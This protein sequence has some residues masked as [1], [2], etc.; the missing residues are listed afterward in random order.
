MPQHQPSL[1]LLVLSLMF[2][3]ACDG[4][5][6]RT[7]SSASQG[8]HDGSRA[9]IEP[10]RKQLQPLDD[11]VLASAG[12]V[13]SENRYL[14]TV[15]VVADGAPVHSRCSGVL[16]HPRLVL[17]A[18][19]C[20]CS[21]REAPASGQ[22]THL[23]SSNCARSAT[24]TTVTYQ[25]PRKTDSSRRGYTG[26]VRPHWELRVLTDGQGRVVASHADLAIIRLDEALETSTVRP[27]QLA[28]G[29]ARLHELILVVGHGY[30]EISGGY[31][32]DRRFSIHRVT[33]GATAED[34]RSLLEQRGQSLYKG[35]SG[36]PC[37]RQ[38]ATG[39]VLVGVSGRALGEV[40]ACTGTGIYQDWLRAEIQHAEGLP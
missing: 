18:G 33:R 36:G 29:E 3:A 19:H 27:V 7:G 6:E 31:D 1:A 11:R 17:T 16:I 37:L 39:A 8:A 5:Q 15:M 35:D 9:G 12:E 4:C 20:V 21:W 26:K 13:D 24:V 10:A 38:D 30:D 28:E 40:P 23:D 2:L 34:D 25:P 22:G 14:S 32:G